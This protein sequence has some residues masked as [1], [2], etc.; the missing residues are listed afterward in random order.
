M[1]SQTLNLVIDTNISYQDQN[2]KI[3]WALVND[4]LKRGEPVNCQIKQVQTTL[5]KRTL[6]HLGNDKSNNPLFGVNQDTRIQVIINFDLTISKP[7]PGKQT[8]QTMDLP[9][10]IDFVSI[11]KNNK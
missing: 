9:E 3:L 11:E 10:E 1:T 6:A 4:M 8:I 5:D 2:S 7:D